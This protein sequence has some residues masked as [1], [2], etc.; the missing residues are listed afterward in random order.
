MRQKKN[1]RMAF[2]FLPDWENPEVLSINRE[3]AHSRWGAYDTSQR[4]LE[5]EYGSSPFVK[6][7]NGT[8]GF[9]LYPSPEAVDDFY[10]PDYDDSLF[11]S[12]PVPSNWE[13]EGFGEPIYTNIVYPWPKNE[14]GC[15]LSARAG[16]SPV[17]NPPYIPEAN[18]TGCYRKEFDLPEHFAGREVYLRFEGVETAFYLWVNGEPV[19]YSQDSKLAA[20]FCVTRYLKPG[21][22]L[23]ALQVMRFADSSYLED[24][25]YWYLSGIYRSVWMIAKRPQHIE[26]VHWK[27]VPDLH[28]GSGVFEADVRVSRVEGFGD[29]RV[30]V[31]LYDEKKRLLGRQEGQVQIEAE[32]RTDKRPTANTARVR[33]RLEQ[34]ELWSPE[35]PVL[36][37]AVFQLMGPD[38]SVLDI[39]SSRFGFKLLEI[40]SGVGLSKRTAG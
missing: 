1:E 12:I 16:E 27:A 36:Y 29:C 18:P 33:L 19:G 13:V 24:Q 26:D 35:R 25:D 8:Y 32:Y 9:R 39:E 21:K 30:E 11:S 10:R 15:L 40:R 3:P 23:M 34:V 20:E 28:R 37:T 17:P 14:K 7:L 31:S 4:A 2:H 6:S 38:G 5:C 22:N